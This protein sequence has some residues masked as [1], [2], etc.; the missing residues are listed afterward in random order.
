MKI[1]VRLPNWLGNMVMPPGFIRQL[2][3]FFPGASLGLIAKKGIHELLPFFPPAHHQFIFSKDRSKG[4]RGLMQFGRTIRHTEQYD[5]FFCLPASLSTAIAGAATG[6]KR[7]IGYKK[8]G[9][10]FLLTHAYTK[11][12]GLHRVQEYINLLEYYT[13][14]PPAPPAVRL[15]HGFARQDHVVM[16]INSEAAS[17]RLTPEKAVELL[18][19]LRAR[20]SQP[21]VLIG[22]PR[23]KV[24]VDHVLAQLPDQRL[25]ENAAGRTSLPQLVSLL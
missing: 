14:R 15:T 17:R 6:A 24:F 20:I 3:H 16:N 8:E 9:R 18:A 1:L 7:R 23:E 5:L 13:G 19:A 22:A 10:G 2:P 21:I 4:I 25:I 11:P 12:Q